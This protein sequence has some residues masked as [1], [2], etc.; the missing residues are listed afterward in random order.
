MATIVIIPFGVT[1]TGVQSGEA[2]GGGVLALQSAGQ[3]QASAIASAAAVASPTL[4]KQSALQV[5]AAGIQTG[6]SVG[7]SPTALGIPGA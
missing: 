4:A 1:L 3:L 7:S 5:A 6:E 2:V